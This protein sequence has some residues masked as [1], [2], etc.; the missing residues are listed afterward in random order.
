MAMCCQGRCFQAVQWAQQP[1]PQRA[2]HEERSV[3]GDCSCLF[4]QASSRII[5]HRCAR[6][7]LEVPTCLSC[8]CPRAHVRMYQTLMQCSGG[9]SLLL[10]T[11]EMPLHF[12][13]KRLLVK[14]FMKLAIIVTDVRPLNRRA[15]NFYHRGGCAI[16]T[17]VAQMTWSRRRLGGGT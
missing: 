11:R 17:R 9:M 6:S 4:E 15:A 7:P 16:A 2:V 1:R 14:I 10:T 13:E 12:I 3:P 8:R 5:S